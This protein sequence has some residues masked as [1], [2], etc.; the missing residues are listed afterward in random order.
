MESVVTR[1]RIERRKEHRYHADVESMLSWDGVIQPAIVRNI[2]MYG[3]LLSG[4]YLPPV[5]TR[6]TLITEHLEVCGT[7]IWQGIDQCGLLLTSAVDPLG[8]IG[9]Q[10][11]RTVESMVPPPVTLQ[12]ISPGFYA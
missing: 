4:A 7:V 11:V 6:V 3:A 9:H 1:A 5:G 8:I 2:S 12:M 10:P